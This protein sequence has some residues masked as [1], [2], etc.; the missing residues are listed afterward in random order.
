MDGIGLSLYINAFIVGCFETISFI[1]TDNLIVILPRRKSVLI[2]I[3]TSCILSL[4][5]IFLETP[6]S[7][8]GVCA[9][10][11]IQV[12]LAGVIF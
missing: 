6:K 8:G 2:G 4:V 3:G 9:V 5:F 12:V 10:L 7:C 1:V 11:I